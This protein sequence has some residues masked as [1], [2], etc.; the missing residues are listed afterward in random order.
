MFYLVKLWRVGKGL[1]E[2]GGWGEVE[3]VCIGTICLQRDSPTKA[4]VTTSL[5]PFHYFFKMYQDKQ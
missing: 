5:F 1:G 3:A 4:P 2:A